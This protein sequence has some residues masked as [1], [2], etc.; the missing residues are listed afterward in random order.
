M[1]ATYTKL[2][3][4]AWGVKLTGCQADGFTPGY[5]IEV[6]KRDGSRKIERI[7]RV[8]WKGEGVMICAIAATQRPARTSGYGGSGYGRRT[9]C[10]CG[11]IED[12]PRD[13]DCRQ[14]R[15]DNE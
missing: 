12:M 15:Y 2:R 8:V 1:Q 4:G 3:T 14:C 13:S 10:R 7:D 11:S 9:G 5:T 6:V